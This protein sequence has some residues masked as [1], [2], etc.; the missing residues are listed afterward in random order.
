[1]TTCNIFLEK[2]KLTTAVDINMLE[3][4]DTTLRPPGNHVN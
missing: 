1:M 3:V 2:E 4:V